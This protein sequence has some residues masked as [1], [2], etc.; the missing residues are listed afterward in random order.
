MER[1][2]RGGTGMNRRR[3]HGISHGSLNRA[4]SVSLA[5]VG[6]AI[7]GCRNPSVGV[8]VLPFANIVGLGKDAVS[9]G[10]VKYGLHVGDVHKGLS[11]MVDVAAG[12]DLEYSRYRDSGGGQW[13]YWRAGVPLVSLRGRRPG[14][15]VYDAFKGWPALSAEKEKIFLGL[16]PRRR[17]LL[18]GLSVKGLDSDAGE[19]YLFIGPSWAFGSLWSPRAGGAGVGFMF[20]L[21]T[22]I[23][24]YSGTPYG[25]LSLGLWLTFGRRRLAP[26]TTEYTVP[27]ELPLAEPPP[28]RLPL[29]PLPQ[30]EVPGE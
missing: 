10:A 17:G 16:P 25:A 23:D 14:G 18:L 6:L 13:R 24:V 7:A 28:P 30:N 20:E 1:A 11:G 2:D 19:R 15:R 29:L 3:A 5:A 26:F 22:G 8:T 21:D 9:A 12:I 27:P 4:A